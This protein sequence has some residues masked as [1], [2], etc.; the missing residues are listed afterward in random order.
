MSERFADTSYWIALQWQKDSLYPIARGLTESLPRDTR[1]VTT[2]LVLVEFLNYAC[3][4]GLMMRMEAA[5]AWDDLYSDPNILILSTPSALLQRAVAYYRKNSDKYWSLTDCVS[6]L[7]M[8]DRN[9]HDALTHDRHF[10]QAGFRALM[11][12]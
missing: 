7:V 10:E 12:N 2:D 3:S 1:I 6:F 9:I 8:Q 11:R 5:I 4:I